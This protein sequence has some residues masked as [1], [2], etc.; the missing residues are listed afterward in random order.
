MKVEYHPSTATDLKEAV[1]YYNK[2]TPYLGEQLRAEVYATIEII[3]Q[4]P[5]IYAEEK[6]VRRA[7]VKRFP[8]SVIYRILSSERL[9][10]L[11]IRH[12]RR[13]PTHGSTRR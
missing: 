5:E 10:V 3:R 4:N 12:H 13:H 7:L 11:V 1:S 9:R 6:G 2:Q 8:Y